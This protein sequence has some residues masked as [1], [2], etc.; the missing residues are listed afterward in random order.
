MFI[1]YYLSD[2]N[3][4][5][6]V[7]NTLVNIRIRN[8]D[9]R[10]WVLDSV[11]KILI[12]K[13]ISLF[14]LFVQ[15]NT[16]IKNGVCFFLSKSRFEKFVKMH[17]SFF[18]VKTSHEQLFPIFINK[19]SFFFRLFVQL[20]TCIKKGVCF[21]VISRMKMSSLTNTFMSN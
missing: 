12:F 17:D 2:K 15:L 21:T 18:F 14:R 5:I 1:F 10:N 20:S 3:N 8:F 13:S 16:C 6:Q 7:K 4:L 11:S 19:I 9:F